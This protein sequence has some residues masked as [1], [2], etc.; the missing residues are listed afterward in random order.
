MAISEWIQALQDVAWPGFLQPHVEVL[1]LWITWAVDYI[2]L[3]YLEYLLW[4][5]LPF[6]ILFIF[7]IFLVLFIY[8]CVIFVHIYGHRHQIREAYHTSYWEGARVAI[9]SF[10]D[11]VGN[12]WHGYELKGIE[13]VPDEGS[14][15]F[16]YYHGCL[17]LDVY[18]LISKLVIHKNRSLHCVGDKFIFKIPG[19]RPLCKLFSITAGTVEECTEELKEGNLLCIAPGGVREALFSDPNVYDILWGKR[20]GFAKVII[21]SKTPVIPMFTENCRESFRT[22]EWGRSF[23][24]WIYEK[25][26]IPLCPIYGGFPVKMITHL[27]KPIYF[28]FDTVTPEEVRKTVKREIRSMI[29]EHQRLP[30][31]VWQGIA[32]RW[33]APSKKKTDEPEQ[34]VSIELLQRNGAGATSPT[35]DSEEVVVL[36]RERSGIDDDDAEVDELGGI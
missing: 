20:L 26:K 16:I 36:R 15:L 14:A 34:A 28:D 29:K 32:Q 6:F 7:P 17:P 1:L 10:W 11:G 23:F 22:P 13:N 3:D 2:D 24:R 19:W 25:T 33:S 27:G 21:G 4:L 12:V 18:Y 9:A 35:S 5:L 8:G 30:G 31:S